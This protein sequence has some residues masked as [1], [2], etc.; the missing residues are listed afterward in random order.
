MKPKLARSANLSFE[1]LVAG[2]RRLPAADRL[3]LI[4][5]VLPRI[6]SSGSTEPGSDRTAAVAYMVKAM[7]ALFAGQPSQAPKRS[8][9]GLWADLGKAP[10]AEEIDEV[11]AEAWANFARAD[12]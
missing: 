9:Y 3:R 5:Q 10:S 7:Q 12:I 6:G 11:R 2:A 1:D 4:E 8:F